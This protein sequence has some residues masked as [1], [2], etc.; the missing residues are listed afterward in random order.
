MKKAGR[1]FIGT[2]LTLRNESREGEIIKAD[3]NSFTPENSMKW[4]STEPSQNNFTFDDSDRYAAYA[5]KTNLQLNCH[6][7]VCHS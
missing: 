1:S 2:A 6:N 3:F 5:K 4:E 7:L